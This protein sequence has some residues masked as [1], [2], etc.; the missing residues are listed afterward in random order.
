MST[1]GLAQAA[2]NVL[3]DV[4]ICVGM[5]WTLFKAKTKVRGDS[6]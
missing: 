3:T 2:V 5:L 6:M 1:S 4:S